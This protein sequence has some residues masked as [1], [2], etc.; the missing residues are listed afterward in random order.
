L[1]QEAGEGLRLRF[2]KDRYGPYADNLRHLLH[3]FEGHFS[4]GFGDGRNSPTT[5]I[6]LL[7]PAVKE[8]EDFLVQNAKA[9]AASLER[10][11]RVAS[12]IRGFE[13]PYGLELL[14]TVHWARTHEKHGGLEDVAKSVREWS[15]R[16]SKLLKREHIELAY[17][18]LEQFNWLGNNGN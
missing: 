11:E 4:L 7:P 9:S 5:E 18:R 15:R 2:Q 6:E 12:L 16:K 14:A 13:S 8:A 1:L 17:R 3:R 10:L